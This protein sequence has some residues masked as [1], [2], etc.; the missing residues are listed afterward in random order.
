MPFEA[1]PY[2]FAFGAEIVRRPDAIWQVSTCRR[3]RAWPPRAAYAIADGIRRAF[4]RFGRR[5]GLRGRETPKS[6]SRDELQPLS[7]R[8]RRISALKK[9]VNSSPVENV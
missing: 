7:I 1:K 6:T 4:T 5:T 8:V 3:R 9:R 2:A